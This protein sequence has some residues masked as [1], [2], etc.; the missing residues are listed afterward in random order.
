MT[1]VKEELTPLG[2]AKF[3]ESEMSN[4]LIIIIYISKSHI[5]IE[6]YEYILKKLSHFSVMMK[7]QWGLS[8]ILAHHRSIDVSWSMTW[9][10]PFSRLIED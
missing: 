3:R 2:T 10:S 8:E 6:N 9:D 4:D 5:T 7:T 1:R